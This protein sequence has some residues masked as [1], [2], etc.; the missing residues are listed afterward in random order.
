MGRRDLLQL[1]EHHLREGYLLGSTDL[2]HGISKIGAAEWRNQILSRLDLAVMASIG[3]CVEDYITEQTAGKSISTLF[4]GMMSDVAA[5]MWLV[6][7]ARLKAL[8]LIC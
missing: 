3:D 6:L 5:L 8:I 2:L 7:G 1:F 4:Y